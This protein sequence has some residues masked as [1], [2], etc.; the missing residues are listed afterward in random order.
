MLLLLLPNAAL[1]IIEVVV[2]LPSFPIH[3]RVCQSKGLASLPAFRD[4]QRRR[5]A[6]SAQLAAKWEAKAQSER[7]VLS[8]DC[9]GQQFHKDY[10]AFA[11]VLLN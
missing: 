4:Q 5:L 7:V 6:E 1:D 9:N 11:T 10:M 3:L 2:L 8:L